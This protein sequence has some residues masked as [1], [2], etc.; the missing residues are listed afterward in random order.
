M[1]PTVKGDSGKQLSII[2]VW[3]FNHI[4][5]QHN[6]IHYWWCSIRIQN[7]GSSLFVGGH[8]I[9]WSSF[10]ASLSDRYLSLGFTPGAPNARNLWS[11]SN[12]IWAK[13]GWTQTLN[14]ILT[15][16]S[17]INPRAGK[18]NFLQI[19]QSR[20]AVQ[21]G[22]CQSLQKSNNN[23]ILAAPFMYVFLEESPWIMASI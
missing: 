19:L 23:S 8:Q 14:S 16:S 2:T 6:W 21:K 13:G 12:T 17:A 9:V 3:F 7:N 5:W 11:R 20:K 4:S 10:K 15:V 22:G 18:S 1:A